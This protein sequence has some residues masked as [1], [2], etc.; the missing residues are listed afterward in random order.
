MTSRINPSERAVAAMEEGKKK[1][2]IKP[3]GFGFNADRIIPFESEQKLI[4]K[5]VIL[6]EFDISI[7][8]HFQLVGK[9]FGP[10]TLCSLVRSSLKK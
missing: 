8:R 9:P 7:P 3:Y 6:S 2:K 1:R 10:S 5:S 4:I